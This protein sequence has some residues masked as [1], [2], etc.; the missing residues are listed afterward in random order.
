MRR[1]MVVVAL[2]VPG[3]ACGSGGSDVEQKL[4]AW[5][6]RCNLYSDMAECMEVQR[7]FL[8]CTNCP[9]EY[10]DQLQCIVDYECNPGPDDCALPSGCG[11]YA[12]DSGT[13]P[14]WMTQRR[15]SIG[16]FEAQP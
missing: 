12:I 14:P 8:G 11:L 3:V 16:A 10:A 7:A 4:E 15:G 6:Q 1:L 13:C 2:L 9:A 5:C